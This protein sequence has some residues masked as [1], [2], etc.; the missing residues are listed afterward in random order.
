M[1]VALVW[2]LPFNYSVPR[3][4]EGTDLP[5]ALQQ[6]YLGDG[7]ARSRC[8]KFHTHPDS[9]DSQSFLQELNANANALD[10]TGTCEK[11]SLATMKVPEVA[12]YAGLIMS[13]C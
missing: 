3:H 5:I 1:V 6:T 11:L 10:T 2:S 7:L 12:I 8:V 13:R 9:S 4:F